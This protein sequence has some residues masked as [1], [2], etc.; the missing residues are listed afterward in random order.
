MIGPLVVDLSPLLFALTVLYLVLFLLDER[1]ARL[2]VPLL[3]S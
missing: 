3:K 2:T 1:P